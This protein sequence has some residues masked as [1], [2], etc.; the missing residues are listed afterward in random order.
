MNNKFGLVSSIIVSFTVVLFAISLIF[1]FDNLGF[2]VCLI[3]SIGYVSLSCAFLNES[4]TDRKSL[5]YAGGAFAVIY[6]VLIN[7]VYFAQLTTVR[8]TSLSKEF[9]EI[10]DFSFYGSLYFNYDLLG[11]SFMSLSLFLLG[12][13]MKPKDKIDR[14]LRLLMLIHGAFTPFFL[15]IPM[16]NV[17]NNNLIQFESM[18][19]FAFLCWC[20]FFLSIGLLSGIHFYKS[21]NK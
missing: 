8:L 9:S 2:F 15:L 4:D 5:S 20:V 18:G 10:L 19:I 1:R 11:Y 3:L 17:F 6:A 13:A 12:L 7:I 21:R 14:I 16:I